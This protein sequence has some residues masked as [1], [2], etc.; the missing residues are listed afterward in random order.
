MSEAAPTASVLIIGDEILSGRTQDA[1]VQFLGQRLG[2]LGIRLQ[3]C[4]I[5]PDVPAAIADALNAMRRTYTYVFTTGGIGPTHDD[6]TTDCVAA[7]FGRKVVRHPKAV[8]AMTAYYG[9][10]LNEARLRMANVP[11][12]ADVALI[13]NH[14]SIAPGYR[15]E[16]VFVLAGVPSVARAMFEAIAPS[17]RQ[18]PPVYSQ[19]A[20][21]NVREGDIAA[22]LERIQAAHPT[23]TIG[24]YPFMRN[25][26]LGASIVARSTD[27][28]EIAA[29]MVKVA[30]M[31]RDHGAEPILGPA[32]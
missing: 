28:A 3:E 29:V 17:L 6:I 7:A 20:D 30:Q 31:M 21:G 26:K 24:S 11:E 9:D 2:A 32:P 25:E 16:N 12:G 4:R 14:I 19:S 15:I 23:V 27:K 13:E 18:G 1:N 5:V 10:K 8:E 22:A